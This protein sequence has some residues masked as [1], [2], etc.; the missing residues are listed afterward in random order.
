MTRAL[1]CLV[2][3]LSLPLSTLATQTLAATDTPTSEAKKVTPDVKKAKAPKPTQIKP[4]PK[5]ERL[6]AM[7]MEPLARAAFF[8]HEFELNPT[9]IEAGIILSEA[10]RA[11]GRPKEAAATAHRVLLFAPKNYEALL[12]AGKSHIADN[13]SFYAVDPLQ[14]A[15]GV[16][17][18]NWQ[19]YSLLGVA[20]DQIKRADEAQTAWDKALKLSPDNPVILTNLAMAKAARGEL[21]SAET[22]LRKA[23]LQKGATIQVRQNLA[24]VLGLQGKLLEAEHLMRRDLPPEVADANLEWLNAA[25]KPSEIDQRSWKDLKDAK[26]QKAGS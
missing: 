8:N 12:A 22:L 20:L 23:S 26:D 1:F 5:A 19:A 2:I 7:R 16:D 9:D 24:L 13:N 3:G 6:A 4:A 15:I 11:L 10:Q 25:L 14:S 18:K 21:A 17:P